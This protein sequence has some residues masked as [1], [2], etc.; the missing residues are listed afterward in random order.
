M[1]AII[2]AVYLDGGVDACSLFVNRLVGQDPCGHSGRKSS[3]DPKTELQEFQQGSGKRLPK[4]SVLSVEGAAHEQVFRVECV[5][6]GST[7]F[8]CGEGSTK[9]AAEQ[10][11][12]SLA[13]KKL[14][15]K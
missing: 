11:A 4:Y 6:T 2:G 13:L 8:F 12:A 5:I 14:K 10:V 15:E 9:R 3:R 7:G 1:E